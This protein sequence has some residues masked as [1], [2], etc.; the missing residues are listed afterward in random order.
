[1]QK[2]MDITFLIGNVSFTHGTNES[3]DS[4][5]MHDTDISDR[6]RLFPLKII[7][8][9]TEKLDIILCLHSLR[10]FFSHVC[11]FLSTNRYDQEF[12]SVNQISLNFMFSLRILKKGWS[13]L[14][15]CF[16]RINRLHWP[17]PWNGFL[18]AYHWQVRND[19]FKSTVQ[20]LNEPFWR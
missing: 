13:L 14:Q 4:I 3:L 7:L 9:P 8:K 1:M 18:D 15:G 12:L 20:P 6:K 19:W 10:L 5:R 16:L 17:V 2:S 11:A